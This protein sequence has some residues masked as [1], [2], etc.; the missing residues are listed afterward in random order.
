LGDDATGGAGDILFDAAEINLLDKGMI[1][2]ETTTPGKAGD[3]VLTADQMK[4]SDDARVIAVSGISTNAGDAG[5][6]SISAENIFE[7]ANGII[8]SA[9]E[10][11]AGGS[12]L[13]DANIIRLSN[14]AV[15]SAKNLETGIAG[16][17]QLNADKTLYCDNSTVTVTAE[18]GE[19][20]NIGISAPEV[21][22]TN[23]AEVSSETSGKGD[24]GDI[25]IR[26]ADKFWIENSKVNAEAKQADGGNIE[27]NSNGFFNAWDSEITA[28]VGGGADTLGGN[29][30]VNSEYVTLS[31]S[32]IIAN[33]YEGRG[34]NVR[35][36]A[37]T[38]VSDTESIVEASSEKGIDGVVEI[39]ALQ[40]V[41]AQSVKPLSE[42]FQSAAAL[43]REPCIV[44]MSEGKSSSFVVTGRDAIPLQPGGLLPSP[45]L[46]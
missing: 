16:G 29:I 26:G 5:D 13:I 35:I 20:G 10:A 39:D 45:V 37:D 28:S 17:V 44:R 31:N 11:G 9:A 40:K 21:F 38:Y 24:A 2:S 19:G 4:I 43:L 32:K 14:G 42:Q 25:E 36:V 6:I 22:L 34:G 1:S 12:V 7:N 8:S 27:I 15:V 18:Q 41:V 3:I 33:A 23:G 46:P 30:R